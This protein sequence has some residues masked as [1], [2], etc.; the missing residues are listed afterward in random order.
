M[1]EKEVF[2]VVG[3]TG[4][5]ADL[6]SVAQEL[7]ARHVPVKWFADPNGRARIDVLEKRNIPYS[8]THPEEYDG[9][10]PKVILCG[11]SSGYAG[12]QVAWTNFSKAQKPAI[13]VYWF[14][15][16]WGTGEQ[17]NERGAD[18][19]VMLVL[20]EL[21]S[22][23]V[24]AK[25]PG[26]QTRIVRK[27]TFGKMPAI[28]EI[29][30][31]RERIRARLRVGESDFLVSWGF[32]GEP[33]KMAPAHV[34]EIIREKLQLDDGMVVAWRPHPK[35]L[36]KDE[37]WA[38][39][40]NGGI[41]FVEEARAVDL[42]ELYL[43]SD[44]VVVP[45]GGTDGYKAVLRGIPTIT[46]MFPSGKLTRKLY[47]FDDEESRFSSGFINGVP[48]LLMGDLSWGAWS[49][50]HVLK[51]LVHIRDRPLSSRLVTLERSIPFQDLEKPGSAA[52][53][54]DEIA[55]HL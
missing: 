48:P 15:D 29:P 20:D 54:A 12:L 1:N 35:H 53:I 43:S 44:A 30:A 49:A 51:L 40:T 28:E 41:K 42:L 45:W 34:G 27:P 39:L 25:R 37:L 31:I 52:L 3:D 33:N 24:L 10:L 18:P 38:T 16:L 2:I 50:A 4:S 21:A 47:D 14:E 22:K 11:T 32:Q 23:I 19:D 8:M 13:P 6:V 55:K 26:I 36:K 46:P 5:A 9:S 7:E 17:E